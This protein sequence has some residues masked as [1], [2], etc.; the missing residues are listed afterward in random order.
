MA[1]IGEQKDSDRRVVPRWRT[2]RATLSTGE[3]S[4]SGRHEKPTELPADELLT[5]KKEFKTNGL[6]GFA[7]DVV[8]TAFA[9]GKEAE[10]EEEA[11]FLLSSQHVPKPLTELA[12]RVLERLPGSLKPFQLIFPT[13]HDTLDK[14]RMR[15][16]VKEAR[17]GLRDDPRN[18]MLWVDLAHFFSTLGHVEKATQAMVNALRLTPSNRFVLRA[19]SRFFLHAG[20]VRHAHN[21]LRSAPNVKTDPWVLSA[22]IAVAGAAHRTSRNVK[23]A[24][25]FLNSEKFSP[26]HT[27]ELASA[28]GTLEMEAAKTK[29][30]KSFVQQSLVRPT[31]NA[32]A[33]AAWLSRN[34]SGI[35]ISTQMLSISPEAS[36]YQGVENINWQ[37]ALYG[38]RKWLMD[39]PFSSRPAILGSY[40]AAVA[41]GDYEQSVE[42]AAQGFLAEPDNFSLR[43]NL[44]FAHAEA[45][46]VDTARELMHGQSVASL[47]A[48]ELPV[49]YATTGLIEFRSG[50]ADRGR[51]LYRSAIA[52]A[53]EN[54]D[55]IRLALAT[56]F[57]SLEEERLA[58]PAAPILLQSA[59]DLLG[60][61]NEPGINALRERLAKQHAADRV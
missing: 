37:A 30:G 24:R 47:S 23:T 4:P 17:A 59:L 45:G 61:V 39:Q 56:A 49:F 34:F 48:E 20:D 46:R 22:E 25:Y 7:A 6:A 13:P 26:L 8:S 1:A 18:V 54:R 2:Y 42:L 27:A 60:K 32:I 14:Q 40:I 55:E 51:E 44:A 33:Q 11:R 57:F 53:L 35:P 58:S 41:V 29:K 28:V 21:L 5:K 38:A 50:N 36:A 52:K 10:A 31:E 3:L 43:N 19:A 15:A 12:Q 9:L 16:A